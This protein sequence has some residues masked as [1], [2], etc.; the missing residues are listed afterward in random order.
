MKNILKFE[1]YINE[2]LET[3]IPFELEY[4]EGAR[5]WVGEFDSPSGMNYNLDCQDM[6]PRPGLKPNQVTFGVQFYALDSDG[7]YVLGLTN[8]KEAYAVLTTVVKICREVIKRERRNIVRFTFTGTPRDG[9][10][11]TEATS[12]ARIYRV[13]INKMLPSATIEEDGNSTLVTVVKGNMVKK[14]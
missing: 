11:A 14:N 8:N 1:E 5:R 7:K 9:E 12:R 10:D 3:S 6:D 2:L 4:F 13:L